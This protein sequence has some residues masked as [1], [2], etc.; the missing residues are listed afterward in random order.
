MV[1]SVSCIKV[2]DLIPGSLGNTGTDMG[3]AVLPVWILW[4][5]VHLQQDPLGERF[6]ALATLPQVPVTEITA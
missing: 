6:K 2:F 5:N 1:T 4:T 3:F